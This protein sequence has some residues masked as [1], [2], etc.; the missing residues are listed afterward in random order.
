MLLQPI[1]K[2]ATVLAKWLKGV[3]VAVAHAC[4]DDQH[5]MFLFFKSAFV[6]AC[7]HVSLFV[8]PFLHREQWGSAEDSCLCIYQ[9]GG[10]AIVHFT[11]PE[12]ILHFG[13]LQC[14]SAQSFQFSGSLCAELLLGALKCLKYLKTCPVMSQV[15]SGV[16]TCERNMS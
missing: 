4:P 16:T 7:V 2:E 6:C 13:T 15:H 5:A 11:F 8:R 10:N 12:H 1:S 9:P 3:T 14:F